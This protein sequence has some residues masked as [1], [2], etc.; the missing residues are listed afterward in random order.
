MVSGSRIIR[1][2]DRGFW[3]GDGLVTRQSFPFTGNFDLGENAFGQ[4]LV[5]NDDLV[6][7][8]SGVD[9]HFHRDVEIVTWMVDGEVRHD[10]SSGAEGLVRAG[11]V[12]AMSAGTG[13]NHREQNPR[14]T[15]VVARAIQMWIPPNGPGGQPEYRTADIPLDG[16]G[17]VLVASGIDGHAPAV[18]IGNDAAA[19]HAARLAAGESVVVPPAR[20][21]HLFVVSGAVTVGDDR[22]AEG[23]AL[24]TVGS[25]EQ[26]VRAEQDGTEV[27]YWEMYAQAVSA[28]R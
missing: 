9:R 11:Q 12:Q 19:L 22:L 27:L 26:T 15:G 18:A 14:A 2:G 21:G 28:L 4:L 13:V 5:H 17:L 16:R 10:D 6:D 7:P 23:D 25:G 20:Y 1:A 8:G 3:R 24:R